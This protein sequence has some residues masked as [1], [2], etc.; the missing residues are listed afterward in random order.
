MAETR[1]H[2]AASPCRPN[3]CRRAG[4]GGRAASAAGRRKNSSIRALAVGQPVGEQ[5]QIAGKARVRRHRMMGRGIERIVDRHAAAA[6]QSADRRRRPARRRHRSGPDRRR[7]ISARN[8]S[9][10]SPAMRSSVAGA[11]TSQKATMRPVRPDRRHACFEQRVED[12]DA[13][14]LDDQIGG[15]AP[16]RARARRPPF[17][18]PDRPRP[19]PRPGR[20]YRD[21]AAGR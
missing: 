21:A 9:S 3:H 16:H 20:R 8:G 17:L 2:S 10:R 5:A 12:A 14:R 15:R 18:R 1:R 19:A 11:S 13:A 4:S 6:R 7:G